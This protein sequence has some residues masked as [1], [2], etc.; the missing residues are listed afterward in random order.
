[1]VGDDRI[2]IDLGFG[3]QPLPELISLLPQQQH[4]LCRKNTLADKSAN[5][6][7]INFH[8][9][10]A[11]DLLHLLSMGSTL[12]QLM[13]SY[14]CHRTGQHQVALKFGGGDKESVG[15]HEGR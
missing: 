2:P 7:E 5:I 10:V 6:R 13:G 4:V 15:R 1:M 12:P 8:Y 14:A 11:Y 9:K 3:M